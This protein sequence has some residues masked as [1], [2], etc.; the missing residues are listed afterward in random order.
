LPTLHAV[1]QLSDAWGKPVMSSIQVTAR[2]AERA[3]VR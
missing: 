2:F 1:A 3:V